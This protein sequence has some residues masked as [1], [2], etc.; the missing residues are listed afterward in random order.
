MYNNI[1]FE[2]FRK[3]E[4]PN[5]YFTIPSNSKLVSEE[6]VQSIISLIKNTGKNYLKTFLGKSGSK[7]IDYFFEGPPQTDKL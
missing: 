6:E 5:E 1:T 2:S 3:I 4:N 7:F